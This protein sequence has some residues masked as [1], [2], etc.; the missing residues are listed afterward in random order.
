[1][2]IFK[3]IILSN[4]YSFTVL[5]PEI[6]R[7]KSKMSHFFVLKVCKYA[8]HFLCLVVKLYFY[9]LGIEGIGTSMTM[10]CIIYETGKNKE[11]LQCD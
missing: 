1:M 11:S 10:K 7:W 6:C 8:L 2:V 4:L 5:L 9:F 3:T